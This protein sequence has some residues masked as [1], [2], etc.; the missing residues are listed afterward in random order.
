M[1][2]V[3]RFARPKA[4]TKNRS[5]DEKRLLVL[6]GGPKKAAL[7]GVTVLADMP[8]AEKDAAR[9]GLRERN[10]SGTFDPRNKAARTARDPGRR[11]HRRIFPL[12][13]TNR[14]SDTWRHLQ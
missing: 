9:P 11:D 8:L 7:S 1:K 4:R 6:N 12:S 10:C 3:F 13:K 2:M 5:V 14:Q